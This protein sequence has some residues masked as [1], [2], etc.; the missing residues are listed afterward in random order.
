MFWYKEKPSI[1]ITSYSIHYTKLYDEN[2]HNQLQRISA[3]VEQ[4]NATNEVIHQNVTDINGLSQQVTLNMKE[5]EKG[6]TGL[7]HATE[8][9]V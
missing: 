7:S 2:T 8:S 3:S 9:I 1:V 6:A 4:L 5:S